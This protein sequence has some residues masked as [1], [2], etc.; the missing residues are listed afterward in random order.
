MNALVYVIAVVLGNALGYGDALVSGNALVLIGDLDSG[1]HEAS[2]IQMQIGRWSAV[3]TGTALNVGCQHLTIPQWR[4]QLKK[5]AEEHKATEQEIIMVKS[6]LAIC[7]KI[8]KL[9]PAKDNQ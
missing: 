6:A 2:P 5:I 7:L 8:Q 4:K 1:S 9:T 3:F